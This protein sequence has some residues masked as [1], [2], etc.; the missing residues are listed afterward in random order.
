AAGT[1]PAA[2]EMLEGEGVRVVEESVHAGYPTDARAVLLIEIDGLA[3]ELEAQAA[4]IEA[5]CRA[6]G[7][8][9]LRAARDEEQRQKLWAGRKGA[10]AA[11][12][13][14]RPHYHI[15]DGV[16]PRSRLT[17]VLAFTEE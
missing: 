16:V 6:N 5:V 1:I 8:R 14:L 3:E 10:L 4:R 15:Q 13:R 7:A 11:C 9:E 2:L 17:E 12:G